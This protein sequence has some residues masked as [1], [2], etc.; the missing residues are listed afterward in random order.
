MNKVMMAKGLVILGGVII[1]LSFSWVMVGGAPIGPTTP[2]ETS[3]P[4]YQ[5]WIGNACGWIM[6]F[7]S[8]Y[9]KENGSRNK[10]TGYVVILLSLVSVLSATYYLGLI[11]IPFGLVG[12]VLAVSESPGVRRQEGLGEARF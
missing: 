10:S 2:W 3:A 1:G 5:S 7:S 12:G 4:A 11:G 6:V 8:L 9:V